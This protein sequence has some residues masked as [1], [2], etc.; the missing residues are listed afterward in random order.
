MDISKLFF[1]ISNLITINDITFIVNTVVL[2]NLYVFIFLYIM[3]EEM[4]FP[5]IIPGEFFVFLT[6][7]EIA[8]GK[9]DPI[10]LFCLILLAT[11]IGSSVLY[12]ILSWKGINFIEKY[13]RYIMMPKSKIEKVQNWF[14]QNGV[15]AIILGRWIFGLRIIT[16]IVSGIFRYPYKKFVFLTMFATFFWILFYFILGIFFGK[17]YTS[18]ISFLSHFNSI[19]IELVYL[20]FITSITFLSLHITK[21]LGERNRPN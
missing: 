14:L 16:N 4:G 11:F 12:S 13:G 1:T 17:Y 9:A 8:L 3:F 6:G 15:R 5:M 10:I 21:K 20:T 18:I 2:P 7:Y 19:V